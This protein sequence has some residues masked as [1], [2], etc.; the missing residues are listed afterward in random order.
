MKKGK[1]IR[2]VIMGILTVLVLGILL[3]SLFGDALIRI[4]IVKGTQSALKVNV[5]LEK[6]SAALLRGKV[7]LEN[8]EIAN[9]PEYKHE[10]FMK[11][12]HVFA[13][14][15]TSSVLSN[16]V[17][18]ETIRLDNIQLVI[19]QKGLTSNL[20]EILNNLPKSEQKETD[21]TTEPK[22]AKDD[23]G[24]NLHIKVLEINNI[25]VKAKL[26][27]V[28]GR[29]DTVTLKIKPIRMENLGTDEKLDIAGLTS[30]IIV[31]ISKG[32]AEQGS[33][34]LPKD[35][36][37]SISGQIGEQGQALIKSGADVGTKAA[38]SATDAVKGLGELFKKKE[39]Q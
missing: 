26:L 1:I 6:F 22:P 16:T 17:E 27:P 5:Q 30:K 8:F 11:M 21:T 39:D 31:A 13:D 7:E 19:E 18:M 29:A 24:K 34:L 23:S 28:P 9:P 36:I 35:M 15:K 32:I 4:A 33:D 38:E 3:F 10:Y 12:G 37:G 25:E 20:K 14:L 2:Y